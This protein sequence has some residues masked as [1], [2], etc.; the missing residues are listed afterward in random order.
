MIKRSVGLLFAILLAAACGGAATGPT[1]PATATR[2]AATA[3]PAPLTAKADVKDKDGATVATATFTEAAV[4]GGVKI[5]LNVT[6]LPAGQHG[7]HLHM[8]GTCTPPDFASAGAH[9]N[10]DGH[11]HGAQNPQGPHAGDLGNVT[12]A[13]DGT[14]KL[15]F[16]AK[17]VTLEAGKPTSLFKDGGTAL[18]IH[19]N[20]DD[21]KTD[22]SGNSGGRIACGLIQK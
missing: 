17:A 15:D 5:A 6:K 12:V 8:T 7:W 10:P 11:Q 1:T 13:A 18:V 22:P 19:A 9:F 16:V 4:G 21:E 14:A 2:A 3:S 20:P